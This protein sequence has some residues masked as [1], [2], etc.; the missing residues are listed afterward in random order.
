ME[1]RSDNLEA[2][3]DAY[4]KGIAC[5]PV[6]EGTKVPA[7]KWK[8]WQTELP[9]PELLEEWFR[10]RSNIA[11][12]CSGMV[13]FDCET[14]EIAD[15]V[16]AHCGDTPHK[17]RSPRGGVHLG[18]R[19]RKGV[20][21]T[22]KVRIKGL[23]IDIRTDGGLE[24]IP[25]SRTPD[26]RYQWLGEGLKPISTL[27]VARIGWTRTRVRKATVPAIVAD[28]PERHRL[29]YRGRL[30][31]DTFE[32]AVSGSNGHTTTFLSARKIVRFVRALGGD[33]AAMWELLRYYNATKCDPEWREETELAHKLKDALKKA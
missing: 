16:L 21:L 3:L 33:E 10:T 22:N 31:V 12:I 15:L 7:V 13:L 8:P 2:A 9:P 20:E 18:Y 1:K 5:I 14:A 11:I 26:G 30:Y 32:R 27:P 4:E 17:V 24:L 28:V 25:P 6:I 29:L 19:R 23:D